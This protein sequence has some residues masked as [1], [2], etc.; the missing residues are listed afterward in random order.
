MRAAMGN[1]GGCIGRRQWCG[2]VLAL[3]V[4]AAGCAPIA[5]ISPERE[6]QIGREE[7]EEVERTMGLVDDPALT[8]YVRQVGERLAAGAPRP[9]AWQ[10]RVADEAEPNA[11]ALPGGF[12]YLTRGLMALLN[13]EDEL[14][15]VLG[16]EMGHVLERHAVRR[17]TAATPFALIFGVPAALLDKVSPTLGGVVGGAGRLASGIVLSPYDREQEREADRLGVSLSASGGWD[18]RGLVGLLRTLEREDRLEGRGQG[19]VSFFSTH[20]STPERVEGIEAAAAPLR[21]PTPAQTAATRARFIS[22]LDRLLVGDNPAYG[23]FAGSLYVHPD[24]D[25]GV[26]VPS[27]WPVRLGP[28]GAGAMSP[29]GSA[30]VLLLAAGQGDDPAQAARREGL[31]EPMVERLRRTEIGGLRAARLVADTRDGDRFDLTWVAHRRRVLR[32][33]AVTSV[34]DWPRHRQVFER[35]VASTRPLASA[36][37]ERVTETRLRLEPARAGERL[38]DVVARAG[39]AWPAPRVAVANGVAV[40][41]TLERGWPVKIAVRQRRTAARSM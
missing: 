28:Q 17:V 4:S 21:R 1:E 27:E 11:F 32:I 20:P 8:A 38:A 6:Q 10:F 2:G 18:P 23:I 12:V 41:A 36:E 3:G 16:H 9:V 34:G 37:R 5:L 25:L 26:E 31:T 29:D 33:T 7:A 35:V 14:A 40:D 13:R 39:G 19:R 15:G 24:L 30:V 22:R